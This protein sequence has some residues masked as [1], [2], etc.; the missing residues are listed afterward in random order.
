MEGRRSGVQVCRASLTISRDLFYSSAGFIAR[1]EFR[2]SRGVASAPVPSIRA[3]VCPSRVCAAIAGRVV[4]S[5]DCNGKIKM[6]FTA[7]ANCWP[8][9]YASLSGR[10]RGT[11]AP[12]WRASMT[13]P[14]LLTPDFRFSVVQ[15]PFPFD[16]RYR[17]VQPTLANGLL[18]PGKVSIIA[19]K[20]G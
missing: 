8:V 17:R 14:R 1:S 2:S 18:C 10:E 7:D 4:Y 16:L 3:R 20:R 9:F 13:L 11:I 6:L 19:G 12:W 15:L 5:P